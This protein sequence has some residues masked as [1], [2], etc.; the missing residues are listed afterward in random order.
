MSVFVDL[1]FMSDLTGYNQYHLWDLFQ[2]YQ[3]IAQKFSKSFN[4]VKGL[5]FNIDFPKDDCK[6]SEF[7][8]F[9]MWNHILL[10]FQKA[11]IKQHCSRVYKNTFWGKFW[12]LFTNILFRKRIFASHFIFRIHSLW[13]WN[14]I[15]EK[16]VFIC[17][18]TLFLKFKKLGS[19]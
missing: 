15:V 16:F 1:C 13:I 5:T 14:E 6:T 19:T 7:Y 10:S 9:F 3:K 4:L 18:N 12:E 2:C 8:E 11:S 17:K